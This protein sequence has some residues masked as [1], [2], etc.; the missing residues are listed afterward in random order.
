MGLSLDDTRVEIE[1]D[2]RRIVSYLAEHTALEVSEFCATV[3][4][5][6]GRINRALWHL[7]KNDPPLINAYRLGHAKTEYRLSAAGW[8]VLRREP[9]PPTQTVRHTRP[10]HADLG[11]TPRGRITKALAYQPCSAKELVRRTGMKYEKV[12]YLLRTLEARCLIIRQRSMDDRRVVLYALKPQFQN[13]APPPKPVL[14]PTVVP[15]SDPADWRT[16]AERILIEQAGGPPVSADNVAVE[17]RVV[18]PTV[19]RKKI[20]VVG[21]LQA[22]HLPILRQRFGQKLHLSFY[23]DMNGSRGLETRIQQVSHVFVCKRRARHCH[24]FVTKGSG[25]PFTVVKGDLTTLVRALENFCD[26]TPAQ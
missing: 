10:T 16:W 4:L 6:E 19:E 18:T 20:L 11:P 23:S 3:D 25:K 1:A 5:P 12:I 24:E 26:A 21:A 13:K 7:R 2:A 22:N 17:P 9:P 14:T 8:K 15:L